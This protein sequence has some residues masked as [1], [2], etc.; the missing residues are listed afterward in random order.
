MLHFLGF[1]F[2]LII[3][4]LIIGIGLIGA[5]VRGLF[6]IGRRKEQTQTYQNGQNPFT[7]GYSFNQSRPRGNTDESIQP[8]EGELH[9]KRKKLFTKEDGEYV[10]FEEIKE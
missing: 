2:I 4:L 3:A 9:I 7:S 5:V 6:H 1:I 8:E 10:D